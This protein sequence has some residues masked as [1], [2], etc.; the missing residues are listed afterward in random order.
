MGGE[1]GDVVV[2]GDGNLATLQD[3][4]FQQHYRAEDGKAGGPNNRY[5]RNGKDCVVRV[6]L[7]TRLT[8]EKSGTHEILVDGQRL[9]LKE[10][11][12]GGRGN[13][14]LRR[15]PQP[16]ECQGRTG[17]A[18]WFDLELRLLADVGVVGPPNAGKS[19]LVRAI[20]GAKPKVA[21][22]PFTTLQP[23]LGRVTS[24]NC[25]FTV[26][27]IPGLLEGA[28]RGSGLGS[29][30]L[31]HISRVRVLVYLVD[32]GSSPLQAYLMVRRELAMY[33]PELLERP[34]LVLLNKV[35]LLSDRQAVTAL[36][37]QWVQAGVKAL[38]LSALTGEGV[39][40]A[41][42]AMAAL[43]TQSVAPVVASG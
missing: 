17:D 37:E 16:H 6:P 36:L 21:A 26:A 7:G 28:H 14:G 42:R 34:H 4:K 13:C 1:G 41:V 43:L 10:G 39:H 23:T 20:S 22:Y 25:R 33:D 24:G 32:V 35:D 27:D 8:G 15:A 29:R 2:V 18:E 9:I 5:G 31:R 30:F 19:S 11:G 38:P 12:G 3:F 40:E